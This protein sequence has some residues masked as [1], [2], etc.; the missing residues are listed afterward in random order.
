MLLFRPNH[1]FCLRVDS[2]APQ[3]IVNAVDA[4]V[5]CYKTVWPG[6]KIIVS[7]DPPVSVYWG[8]IRLVY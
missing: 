2:K 8:D 5:G 7:K 4:I 3:K 6:A 1:A